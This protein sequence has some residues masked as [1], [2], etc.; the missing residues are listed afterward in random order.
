MK[1]YNIYVLQECK[2]K[3]IFIKI[4]KAHHINQSFLLFCLS[5]FPPTYVVLFGFTTLD[6]HMGAFCLSVI[7][8]PKS[9]NCSDR[10]KDFWKRPDQTRIISHLNTYIRMFHYVLRSYRRPCFSVQDLWEANYAY[11]TKC[12]DISNFI[13][14]CD[15]IRSYQV[16]VLH[17]NL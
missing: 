13:L 6:P 5:Y 3:E 4:S 15:D 9:Q 1:L 2:W 8:T 16:L 12:T 17:W 14:I 7:F 11:R 10:R